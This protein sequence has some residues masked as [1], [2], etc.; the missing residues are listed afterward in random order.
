MPYRNGQRGMALGLQPI[1][2]KS[3][4]SLHPDPRFQDPCNQDWWHIPACWGLNKVPWAVVGLTP[5]FQET[6]PCVKDK[7][8]GGPES[9]SSGCAL[10]V[11]RGPRHTVVA[12]PGHCSLQAG[13]WLCRVRHSIK[14]Q[15][16]TT[17]QHPQHWIKT[18]AWS[19]LHQPSLQFVCWDQWSSL[20]S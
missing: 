6:H 20:G 8:Q 7:V 5:L 17:G 12:V 19:I 1:S 15:P 10:E 13:L 16:A 4:I 11:G 3:Y 9:P 14:H 18:G 2:V